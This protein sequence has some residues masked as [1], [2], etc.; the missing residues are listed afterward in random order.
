[1][2][3]REDVKKLT[4][5]SADTFLHYLEL[6]PNS[7]LYSVVWCVDNWLVENNGKEIILP[8]SFSEDV[9]KDD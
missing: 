1:M 8:C 6:N 5:G 3:Y 9:N 7:T 4:V 2:E